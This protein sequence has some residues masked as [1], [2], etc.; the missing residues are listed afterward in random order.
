MGRKATRNQPE[1]ATRLGTFA[2]QREVL[3][4]FAKGSF[5]LLVLKGRPGITKSRHV[6]KAINGTGAGYIK[7]FHTK[8]DY[9]EL[10]YQYQDK[11]IV[12]DDANRL[13]EDKDTREMTRDLTET[14]TYKKLEYGSTSCIL[15]KKNLPRFFYTKSPVCF[16]TNFWNSSDPVFQALESRAEFFVIEVTWD[17]L[18]LDVANWFWDQEIF[19]YVQERLHLLREP[20]ARLYV[21][22][23]E[24]KKS[25]LKLTPWTKLIDDYCDD[26]HGLIIRKLLKEELS[27][28]NLRFTAYLKETEKLGIKPLARSNFY[29]RCKKIRSCLPRNPLPK[30]ILENTSPPEEARPTDGILPQKEGESK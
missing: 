30:I 17:E 23:W 2:E 10:L 9:Y 29:A 18:H 11:P 25:G 15:E 14:D 27:S 1:T 4:A 28:D 12:L 21:K 3:E 13:L 8:L 22:A 24:R 7:G 16:I 5:S 19:N 20:D 6:R 26:P